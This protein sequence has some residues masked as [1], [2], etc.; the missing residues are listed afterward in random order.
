MDLEKTRYTFP[1]RRLERNRES[2]RQSRRRKKQYL[3]LLEGRVHDLHR[4]IA[5]L[6]SAHCAAADKT[7]NEQRAQLLIMLVSGKGCLH[8]DMLYTIN[9]HCRSRLRIRKPD[10]RTRKPP[11]RCV[12][13][14]EQRQLSFDVS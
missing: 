11:Y 13:N 14:F 2:A 9:R 12:Y 6:R 3:E 7:L 5:E 10:L 4:N 1:W 8:Y